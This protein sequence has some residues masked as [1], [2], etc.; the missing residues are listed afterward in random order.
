MTCRLLLLAALL[1]VHGSAFA[2]PRTLVV[3]SSA[4]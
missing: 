4:T 3:G 1:A 2:Q